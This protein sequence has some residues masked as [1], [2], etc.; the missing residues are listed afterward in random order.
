MGF[1]GAGGGKSA[2]A[3]AICMACSGTK[4]AHGRAAI[5]NHPGQWRNNHRV[6]NRPPPGQSG[7][8]DPRPAPMPKHRAKAGAVGQTPHGNEGC[9]GRPC[10]NGTPPPAGPHETRSKGGYLKGGERL[11][12]Q[13]AGGARSPLARSSA[14]RRTPRSRARLRLSRTGCATGTGSPANSGRSADPV[15]WQAGHP[16]A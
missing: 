7:K 13:A 2:A 6:E 4:A 16:L 1:I 5:R 3:M 12:G 14:G 11:K 9:K 15:I 8:K 10:G